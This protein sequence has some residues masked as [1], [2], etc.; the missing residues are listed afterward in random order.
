MQTVNGYRAMTFAALGLIAGAL[1]GCSADPTPGP[2]TTDAGVL[3]PVTRGTGMTVTQEVGPAGAT[4]TLESVTLMV[5]PGALTST[6]TLSVTSS[7]ESAP[8]G[9]SPYS[10][11]YRFEPD[12]LAF[13]RPVAV[14][15]AVAADAS[16]PAIYWTRVGSSEF[17]ELVGAVEG[18]VVR[19]EVTHFS[20]GFAGRRRRA[21]DGG[22]RDVPAGLD[23]GAADAPSATDAP[24]EDVICL[25]AGTRYCGAAAGCVPIFDNDLHCGRCDNAC[26]A[27]SYTH[28][29]LPTKRKV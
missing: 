19:A 22:A 2:A 17:E 27:V 26:E 7:M 23:T 5:P 24:A 20:R 15:V 28:L 1:A 8:S 4:I 18:G 12:G 29:T 10:P 16:D 3:A 14:R 9:D 11:V 13:A 6:R 25:V 21:P